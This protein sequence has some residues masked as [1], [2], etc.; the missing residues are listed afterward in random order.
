MLAS[1]VNLGVP[2]PME[3][4]GESAVCAQSH[5]RIKGADCLPECNERLPP[6]THSLSCGIDQSYD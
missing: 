4:A 1:I 3:A 5:N 2:S 6:M